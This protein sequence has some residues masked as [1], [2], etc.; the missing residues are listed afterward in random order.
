MFATG[1]VK[2]GAPCAVFDRRFGWLSHLKAERRYRDVRSVQASLMMLSSVT[3]V[4]LKGPSVLHHQPL[5]L[6][7]V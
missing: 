1:N 2:V 3:D 6:H 7:V 5:S 4:A